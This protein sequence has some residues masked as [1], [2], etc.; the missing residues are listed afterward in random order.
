MDIL[1][2]LIIDAWQ[3]GTLLSAP[4]LAER[5]YRDVKAGPT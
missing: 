4:E 1:R 2:A 5:G 3:I